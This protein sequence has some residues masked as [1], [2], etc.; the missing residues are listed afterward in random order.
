MTPAAGAAACTAAEASISLL[1]IGIIVRR[2]YTHSLSI[3][4]T[5]APAVPGLMTMNTLAWL[6]VHPAVLPIFV[7]AAFVPRKALTPFNQ[8]KPIWRENRR[9][10]FARTS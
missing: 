7:E 10:A 9:T 6:I 5:I 1:V 3:Q 2:L 4:A 8:S